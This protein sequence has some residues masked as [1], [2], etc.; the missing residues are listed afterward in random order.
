MDHNTPPRP[1]T[2]PVTDP[3]SKGQLDALE[4]NCREVGVRLKGR[5][6]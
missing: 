6:D 4:G 2:D 5:R 3:L 1:L